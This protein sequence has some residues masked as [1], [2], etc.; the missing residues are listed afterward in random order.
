MGCLGSGAAS[1]CSYSQ[2][3]EHTDGGSGGPGDRVDRGAESF[4]KM[5]AE[6]LSGVILMFHFL[7][8]MRITQVYAFINIQLKVFLGF[9]NH[10]H[11]HTHNLKQI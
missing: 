4:K 7:V 10:T 2:G 6:E 5:W 1:K 11:T 9:Y 8:E 3:T